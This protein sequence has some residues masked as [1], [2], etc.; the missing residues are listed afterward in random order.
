MYVFLGKMFAHFKKLGY[1]RVFCYSV[2]FIIKIYSQT[3][4]YAGFTLTCPFSFIRH[5]GY[6]ERRDTILIEKMFVY[7]ILALLLFLSLE[8]IPR[9][10][11][12]ASKDRVIFQIIDIIHCQIAFQK[13]W[14]HLYYPQQSMAMLA[15]FRWTTLFLL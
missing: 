1:L 13:Y 9:N 11:M 8:L 4:Y 15:C 5:I 3:T 10:G 6:F 2:D 14:A 7:H 12:T